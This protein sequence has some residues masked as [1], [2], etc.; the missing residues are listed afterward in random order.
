MRAAPPLPSTIAGIAVPGDDVSDAAWR[1]AHRSLPR[2]PADAFGPHLLLG[3][4]H[5]GRGG[6]RLRSVHPVDGV[7]DA[8]RRAHPD[9]GQRPLL[10][11]RRRRDRTTVPPPPRRRLADVAGVVATAI[12]LHMAPSVTLDDGVE[13]LLLDRATGLDVRGRRVRPRRRRAAGRHARVPAWSVRPPLPR[14]HPARG[15]VPARLSEQPAPARGRSGRLDGP[16]AV[17]GP[18]V[19]KDAP[20]PK[21]RAAGNDGGEWRRLM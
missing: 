5:R 13:A 11:G 1:W 3:R 18:R 12:V 8:R 7:A 20:A 19:L 15:R 21:C 2:L 16:L 9:P 4:G 14:R 17:A 6:A 10:R